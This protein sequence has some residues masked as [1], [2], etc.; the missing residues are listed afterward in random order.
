ML[1][2]DFGV[3]H[4]MWL[5]DDFLYDKKEAYNLFNKMIQKI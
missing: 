4:I 1:K 2:N 5:D 3:N